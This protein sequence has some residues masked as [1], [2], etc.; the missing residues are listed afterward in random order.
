MLQSNGIDECIKH[1]YYEVET[2]S[3]KNTIESLQIAMFKARGKSLK[4]LLFLAGII[5]YY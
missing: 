3:R 1:N 4:E 2:N 5:L